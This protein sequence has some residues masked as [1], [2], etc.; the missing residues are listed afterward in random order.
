MAFDIALDTNNLVNLLGELKTK[1]DSLQHWEIQQELDD[2]RN[3]YSSMLRYMV[4]D[5]DDPAS[6]QLLNSLI[7]R[8]YSVSD[9]IKRIERVKKHGGD[10]YVLALQQV[11]PFS[12]SEFLQVMEEYGGQLSSLNEVEL[13]ETKRERIGSE[14]MAKHDATLVKLFEWVWTSD[15]WRKSDYEVAEAILNSAHILDMDKAVF[16]SGVTL[17]LLEMFDEKKM[18]LLLDAYLKSNDEVCQRAIVG[19]LLV[20]RK[21]DSRLPNYPELVS[22]ITIYSDDPHFVKNLFTVL[23]Q[24]QFSKLTDKITDKMRND[25]IPTIIRSKKF[26]KSNPNISDFGSEFTQN[27]ENPE[28]Y[29]SKVDSRASAKIR[30]MGE[31]QLEGADVYMG[32]FSYMKS[33]SFFN[34]LPHWFYPFTLDLPDL[35]GAKSMLEKSSSLFK[36][37]LTSS[38]LCYSDRYS[39]C[40]MLSS[41]GSMAEQLMNQQL[42]AELD[43]EEKASLMEEGLNYTPKP[44]DISR[45]YIY[46]LYRFFKSFPAKIEFDDVFAESDVNFSPMNTSSLHFM[47]S[48]RDEMLMLGEFF[49]RKGFYSDALEIFSELKSEAKDNLDH[50]WQKI[51]FCH[52]RL[53]DNANALRSYLMAET[54][55]PSSLWTIKHLA[56]V[57]FDSSHYDIA[58]RCIDSIIESSPDNLKW[59]NRKVECMFINKRYSE[60]L[61]L[62][63]KIDFLADKSSQ[64]HNRLALALLLSGDVNKATTMLCDYFDEN[65][66][67]STSALLLAFIHVLYSRSSDAFRLLCQV[68]EMKTDITAFHADYWRYANMFFSVGLS[69]EKARLMYDAVL[70]LDMRR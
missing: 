40:L 57:A 14:L 9:R 38:P 65:P 67:D 48:Y 31:L 2:I 8:T 55:D 11:S 43:S 47:K 12:L 46:D 6:S 36:M 69:S 63:Y 45:F 35:A 17:G 58:E 52:Q 24:L 23:M 19:L 59:L 44:S 15:V 13:R 28:W 61:P 29:D 42:S 20:L 1:V 3:T 21:Y 4:M 7:R 54:Y 33:N 68:R 64:T 34:K 60:S 32:T 37:M 56:N 66:D 41:A 39:L 53:G 26:N 22:R 27:G 70:L 50:L 5:V 16:V 25:I 18:M 51:G 49:M 10:K 62:L 30:E